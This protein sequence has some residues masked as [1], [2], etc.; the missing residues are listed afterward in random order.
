M[1]DTIN[2]VLGSLGECAIID[3][4]G[5]EYRWYACI[6]LWD[7]TFNDSEKL[8]GW[9]HACGAADVMIEHTLYCDLNG[10]RNGMIENTTCRAWTVTFTKHE[11]ER[12]L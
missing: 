1:L 8:A 6:Y 12:Y 9:F 3:R 2:E 11:A 10:D 5:G 4:R 7:T